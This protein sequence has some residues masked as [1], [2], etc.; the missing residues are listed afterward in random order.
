MVRLFSYGG[1]MIRT[2]TF[3]IGLGGAAGLSQFPEFS[4]Q[5]VQ[6][7]GGA[8]DELTRV[9][10]DFDASAAAEGLTRED[11]LAQMVGTGFVERRR[12][13][14]ENTFDRLDRLSADLFAL[15]DA[16]AVQR[17]TQAAR[18]RDTELAQAT[19]QDFKPAVPL[20][21]DGAICALVGFVAAGGVIGAILRLPRLFRR[22]RTA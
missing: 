7:L 8:V 11:A 1:D 10:N 19:W 21:L 18:L 15:R 16:S 6:R 9:A 13:D 12:V 2:L 17:L 5:Y 14:M 20:T 3:V 4:Q 22:R